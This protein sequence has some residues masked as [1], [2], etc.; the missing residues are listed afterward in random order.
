MHTSNYR[1]HNVHQKWHNG[2]WTALISPLL[3]NFATAVQWAVAYL[4]L[5]LLLLPECPPR[6]AR[7]PSQGCGGCWMQMF[8]GSMLEASSASCLESKP[9]V[10]AVAEGLSQQ[11]IALSAQKLMFPEVGSHQICWQT[12]SLVC[13]VKQDTPCKTGTSTAPVLPAPSNFICI[14]ILETVVC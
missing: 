5:L 2:S 4:E 14:R 7:V 3:T 9:V 6:L 1:E 12:R 10:Q 8:R 13:K 11:L